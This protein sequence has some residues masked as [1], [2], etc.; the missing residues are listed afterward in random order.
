MNTEPQAFNIQEFVCK[1]RVLTSRIMGLYNYED[2][3][4]GRIFLVS[5]SSPLCLHT[6]A[7]ITA[8]S[9]LLAAM[10]GPPICQRGNMSLAQCPDLPGVLPLCCRQAH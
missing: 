2:D 9:M 6:D 3:I 1:W 4:K 8:H 7:C 5:C 10:H